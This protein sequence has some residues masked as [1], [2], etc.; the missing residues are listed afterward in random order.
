MK[1]R[2][3]LGAAG[4]VRPILRKI[5]ATMDKRATILLNPVFHHNISKRR[6]LL[7]PRLTHAHQLENR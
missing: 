2:R 5:E 1:R 6:R 4:F 7:R 3:H